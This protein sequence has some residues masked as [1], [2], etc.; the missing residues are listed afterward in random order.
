[1][2]ENTRSTCLSCFLTSQEIE[3]LSSKVQFPPPRSQGDK[4]K[5]F[6]PLE[7]SA[8]LAFQT[9]LRDLGINGNFI[10]V[11]SHLLSSL[12]CPMGFP[13]YK[14][15]ANSNGKMILQLLIRAAIC[16]AE[17]HDLIPESVSCNASIFRVHVSTHIKDQ[18]SEVA[19][20]CDKKRTQDILV[21]S[22]CSSDE[23]SFELLT[24]FF[25]HL[26]AIAIGDADTS[27]TLKDIQK[28]R[29]LLCKDMLAYKR[30]FSCL[31]FG[32]LLND[33]SLHILPNDVYAEEDIKVISLDNFEG[34]LKAVMEIN[35]LLH[36]ALSS[37]PNN[38]DIMRTI[39]RKRLEEWH[40]A[41]KP[42]KV[43]KVTVDDEIEEPEQ[44]D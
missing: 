3:D 37:L 34:L 27:H 44:A 36:S 41:Y 42:Q 28:K 39:R 16:N 29:G 31:N 23:F 1:M 10:S 25:H 15:S 38:S 5:Y 24:K 12:F 19:S 32:L 43:R 9:S 13:D 7:M 33:F 22:V 2:A 17:A 8:L 6:Q 26:P 14:R 30:G 11:M 4:E 35:I 40:A 21:L 18:P 20:N